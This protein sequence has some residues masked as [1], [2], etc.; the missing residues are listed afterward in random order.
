[1]LLLLTFSMLCC[2]LICTVLTKCF[3]STKNQ[4]KE[5]K[6]LMSGCPEARIFCSRL[7]SKLAE[8]FMGIKVLTDLDLVL[9][10]ICLHSFVHPSPVCACT[11]TCLCTHVTMY[12]TEPSNTQAIYFFFYL[13][14]CQQALKLALLSRSCDQ[15]DKN[16]SCMTLLDDLV[17]LPGK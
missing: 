1:M 12:S 10:S 5:W 6:T 2:S 14:F 4:M 8:M 9:P 3:P 11:Y 16:S 17:P 13:F 15:W 7:Y